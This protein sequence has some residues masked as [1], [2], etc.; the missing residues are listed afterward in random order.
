MEAFTGYYDTGGTQ[1]EGRMVVTCGVVASVKEWDD[2]DVRWNRV[3]KKYDMSSFHMV[4]IAHWHKDSDISKWSLVN[5]KRDEMRRRKLLAE[6]VG[7]AIGIKMAFVRGASLDDYNAYN[8]QYYLTEKIGGAYTF[9]QAQ[10]LLHS[11]GW[12]SA[13]RE[14]QDQWGSIVEQGDAGQDAFRKFCK[15]QL[16][17]MPTFTDKQNAS[18]EDY[19]PLALADLIAYE[20]HNWYTKVAAAKVKG[21]REPGPETW[22][23]IMRVIRESLPI[24]AAIIEK[25]LL[26]RFCTQ[27]NLPRRLHGDG[28][29][30]DTEAIQWYLDRGLNWP[31]PSEGKTYRVRLEALRFPDGGLGI[32]LSR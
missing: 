15:E 1:G 17:Y 6:L 22:R 25:T 10:C 14:P 12:L 16:K 32:V 8:D 23:G 27:L 11:E 5:G 18:G 4:K 3:M 7:A 26:E 19:T 21:E 28:V 13:R 31:E 9:A 2:F 20:H 30:D 24:N 29:T